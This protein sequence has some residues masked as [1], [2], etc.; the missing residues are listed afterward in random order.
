MAIEK[1][2]LMQEC[3]PDEHGNSKN[4]IRHIFDT[5]QGKKERRGKRKNH[6]ICSGK[7]NN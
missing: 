3:C 5:T 4:E 1:A 2:A 6:N 7:N